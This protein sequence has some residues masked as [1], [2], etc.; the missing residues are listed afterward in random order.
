MTR[1]TT[2]LAALC[3]APSLAFA[4]GAT[5]PL[6]GRLKKVQSTRTI[7]VAY[8]PDA[9][10]FSFEDA[11]KKPA[12]YTVDLCR[13]VVTAI[14]EQLGAGSLKVQWVPVTAQTRFTAIA[15]GQ[16]DME[17]GAS[18]VTL[19]R[20][21]EVGFSSLVFVDGTGLL[22]LKST[23]GQ[24]L[25]DLAGKKIGVVRGTSN[26]RA[27]ADAMKSLF[28]TATVVP[29]QSREEGLAQLESGAIDAVA[30]DRVLLLGLASGS[31]DP[32]KLVLLT[33]AFSFEPYAIALPRGDWAMQQAVDAAL[34]KVY[35]SPALP[36]I[37][38]RWFAG[39]GEPSPILKVVYGLGRLPQ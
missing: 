20:K 24:S 12:G 4:Q 39:L 17:C 6:E 23:P 35:A 33:D 34:A 14:E 8:R 9:M 31:K 5:P 11:E 2:L 36:D 3:L 26:E 10:P 7:A 29:L 15:S 21:K 28:I 1:L 32:S 38:A 30:S 22:A 13:A 16:A 18:T 25:A 19:G 27:L 37:Y